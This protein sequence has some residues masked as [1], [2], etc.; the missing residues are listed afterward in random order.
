M[1][2]LFQKSVDLLNFL[3]SK[4]PSMHSFQILLSKSHIML[5]NF[6]SAA[7][8]I[9]EI[10]EKDSSNEEAHLLGLLVELAK[11]AN[12]R[13]QKYITDATSDNFQ[14]LSNPQFLNV[15]ASAELQTK[16]YK[17]TLKTL[18][19][20]KTLVK[21]TPTLIPKNSIVN[22]E[23]DINWAI[24]QAGTGDIAAAKEN[25]QNAISAHSDSPVKI[26]ILLAN[27]EVLILAGDV[28]KAIDVL[29]NVE[30]ADEGYVIA[31][32][33]LAKIFQEVVKQPVAFINCYKEIFKVC[34]TP[35]NGVKL[36]EVLISAQE[37][38][39]ALELIKQLEQTQK[40]QQI[41]QKLSLYGARCLVGL[42]DFKAA[43]QLITTK[44][45]LNSKNLELYKEL[46]SLLLKTR[47]EK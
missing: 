11:G 13:P 12:G 41:N 17:A 39:E 36:A 37:Y 6:E 20:I 18:T 14:L 47:N 3:S 24:T 43:Q 27:S 40:S 34:P 1:P 35:E 15:K 33:R 19:K 21:N 9:K 10:L 31:Q 5:G 23:I 44:Y 45:S 30:Q 28:K 42:S 22:L 26:L 29:R 38:E 2:E 25:I 7:S 46:L 32:Q 8:L 4:M 16:D